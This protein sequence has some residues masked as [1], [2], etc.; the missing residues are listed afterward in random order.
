MPGYK[1]KNTTIWLDEGPVTLDFVLD[2]EGGVKGNILQ[3]VYDCNCNSKSKLELVQFFGGVHLEVYFVFIVIL[4]FL[5]ILF[6]RRVKVK[7][8]QAAGAKRSVVV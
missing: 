6:Q 5:C 8:R 3:N 2:P 1:S 4:G 7:N